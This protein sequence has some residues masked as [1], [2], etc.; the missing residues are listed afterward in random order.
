MTVQLEAVV[1]AADGSIVVYCL[2]T[3]DSFPSMQ[4]P[5]RHP[6]FL[7]FSGVITLGRGSA[8]V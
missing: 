7:P 2:C 1:V 8:L 5:P 3:G 4:I 6:G